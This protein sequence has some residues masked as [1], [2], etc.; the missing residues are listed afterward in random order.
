MTAP[1]LR[2]EIGFGA[3]ASLG[4]FFQLDDFN[5]DG[6]AGASRLYNPADPTFAYDTLAGT[7]FVDVTSYI[8]GQLTITRGRSR[9]TDQYGAGTMSFT[10]RNEDRRFDP[11]NTA[12][13]Y[14]PGP[15]PRLLV[16]AYL[17][18]G[19]TSQQVFAGYLDD[20]DI[21]YDLDGTSTANVTCVD[22]FNILA[23]MNL[24]SFAVTA[25]WTTGQ[26]IKKALKASGYPA[27]YSIDA[28]LTSV[29]ASTQDN[30]TVLDFAQTMAR[31][32]NGFFFTDKSGV[33]TF[34]NRH[35]TGMGTVVATFSDNPSDWPTAIGYSTLAQKSAALLLYNEVSG[36]RNGSSSTQIATDTASQ[37][38]YLPRALSL[39][40][41]ENQTNADVANLCAYMLGRYSQPEVRFDS[42]S[43]ELA[44]VS[45]DQATTILALGITDTVQVTHTPPGSGTPSSITQTCLIDGID[46]SM[47]ASSGSFRVTYNLQLLRSRQTFILDDAA[48]GVLDTSKLDY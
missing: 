25:G 32:E 33:V 21:T 24:H 38:Q 14:Y 31:S 45:D 41:L 29:Q 15:S 3:T 37:A 46:W 6:S 8:S 1:S 18:K 40:T 48:L 43:L 27:T 22:A 2:V 42:M 20:I 30:V 7:V 16:N 23:N 5:A 47:D 11:S 9:E 4:S 34:K 39:S 19:G 12:G 10:L 36:Q 35:F 13:P 17:T 28:G 44:G 26:A